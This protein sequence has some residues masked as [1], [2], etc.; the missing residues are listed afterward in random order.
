MTALY[1]QS[2]EQALPGPERKIF[3]INTYPATDAILESLTDWPSYGTRAYQHFQ[4]IEAFKSFLF[5]YRMTLDVNNPT[6]HEVIYFY[7]DAIHIL[8]D[9]LY[10]AVGKFSGQWLWETLVAYQLLVVGME[11]I[12]IERTLGA[13][14]YTQGGFHRRQD[15][16]WCI[17]KCQVGERNIW[18]SQKYSPL[19][20]ENLEYK[21][22]QLEY[23]FRST[24]GQLRRPIQLNQSR[25]PSWQEGN[26]WFNNMT[27]YIDTLKDSQRRMTEIIVYK[28]EELINQD[29]SKLG[30]RIGI[31]AVVLIMCGVIIKA[32]EYSKLCSNFSQTNQGAE[33]RTKTCR[34][35]SLLLDAKDYC[36]AV[37]GEQKCHCRIFLRSDHFFSDIVDF[38][39]ICS[40]SSPMQVV[41]LLNHVYTTFDRR[42][43]L[44]DVYKVETI[45]DAYMVVSGI[46]KPNGNRHASEIAI[47]AL[48]MVTFGESLVIP[49]KPGTKMTLRIG[50]HTGPVA[51]GIVANRI[52]LSEHTFDILKD[53]EFLVIKQR[54]DIVIKGKVR[55]STYWLLE[56]RGKGFTKDVQEQLNLNIPEI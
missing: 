38:T 47:M 22:Q 10:E 32:V 4:N 15:Y 12:G 1:I 54:G 19:V 37:D 7:T 55:M 29:N 27:I 49:H 53:I 23:D 2:K 39:R 28:L 24:I 48:D 18:A 52:Q 3:L 40:D 6:I 16:L 14:F 42:I 17:E 43:D 26:W 34:F 35:Y 36:S 13:V 45:G 46:P 41:E 11:Q 44:Y 56:R 30:V 8:S 33:Q 25:E 9:W 21:V 51:A 20:G 31:M 5:E 50:I